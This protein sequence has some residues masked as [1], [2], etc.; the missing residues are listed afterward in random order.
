MRRLAL[1][2]AVA[3]FLAG[4]PAAALPLSGPA[5]GPAVAGA[6]YRAAFSTLRGFVNVIWR[7]RPDGQVTAVYTLDRSAGLMGYREQGGDVGAWTVQGDRLCLA[8]RQQI[9]W[10]GC[11]TVDLGPG[12]RTRLVGPLTIEGTLDR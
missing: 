9:D 5:L 12:T 7:F 1:V 8:F 3:P 6:E 4:G 2:L 11:Y 10:N